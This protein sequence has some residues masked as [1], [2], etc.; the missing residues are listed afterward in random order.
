MKIG[1]VAKPFVDQAGWREEKPTVGSE[2]P[3]FQDLLSQNAHRLHREELDG[4]MRQIDA[5]GQELAKRANW[6]LL[7]NY[8]D[9]VRRFLEAIV[10]NGYQAKERRGFDARGRVK[11][12]KL[13]EQLDGKLAELAEEVMREEKDHLKILAM[14]GEIRGLLLNLY[15]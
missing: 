7:M 1:D 10:K 14:I 11:M 13:V 8:K 6:R 2:R 5:T 12:Y 9:L 4:L 15:F 3:L